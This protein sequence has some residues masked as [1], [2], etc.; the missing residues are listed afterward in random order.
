MRQ[1]ERA[2]HNPTTA[3]VLVHGVVAGRAST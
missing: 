1:A 2:G 3:T